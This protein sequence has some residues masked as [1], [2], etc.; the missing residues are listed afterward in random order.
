MLCNVVRE[1]PH[2]ARKPALL[3]GLIVVSLGGS[4][5]EAGAMSDPGSSEP[6]KATDRRLYLGMWTFH[7]RD[8]GRG[9]DSNR[10]VGMSWGRVYGATFVNSFGKRSYTGGLQ[11]TLASWSSPVVSLGLGYRAG[12]VTGYDERLFPLAGKTPVL[13][14]LQPLINLDGRRMGLELSYSGVVA[15]AALN[16]RW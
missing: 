2:S 11:G 10:L 14:L 6:T 9:L 15:S 7:F 4:P 1:L 3:L 8:V 5:R 12:L 13:P 16:V